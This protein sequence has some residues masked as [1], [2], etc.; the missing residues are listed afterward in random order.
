MLLVFSLNFLLKTPQNAFILPI[1]VVKA[2][3]GSF[4]SSP[5]LYSSSSSYRSHPCHLWWSCADTSGQQAPAQLLL[6]TRPI[7]APTQASQPQFKEFLVCYIELVA[8]NFDTDI[9]LLN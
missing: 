9:V 3:C 8:V 4:F 5:P 7:D 6:A 2:S 1:Q